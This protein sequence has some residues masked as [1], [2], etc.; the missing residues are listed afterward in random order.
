MSE[1]S[2]PPYDT[3]LDTVLFDNTMV[4]LMLP[5]TNSVFINNYRDE[6]EWRSGTSIASA[7]YS[8]HQPSFL[9]TAF[10]TVYNDKTYAFVGIRGDDNTTILDSPRY[11][12]A[13]VIMADLLGGYPVSISDVDES[14]F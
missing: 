10:P 2:Y 6:E 13:S 5:T 14:T 12:E 1:G 4:D 11:F 7:G 3:S 9:R 8:M